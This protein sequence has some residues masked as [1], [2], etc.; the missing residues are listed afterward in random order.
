MQQHPPHHPQRHPQ[1][2]PRYPQ[3][4]QPYPPGPGQPQQPQDQQP[5]QEFRRKNTIA[6]V[7]IVLGAL[8][9][10]LFIGIMVIFGKMVG[11]GDDLEKIN[12]EN[13]QLKHDNKALSDRNKFL[14]ETSTAGKSSAGGPA[15]ASYADGAIP[16]STDQ[17]YWYNRCKKLEKDLS[18]AIKNASYIEQHM[19]SQ[20]RKQMKEGED[21]LVEN[22]KMTETADGYRLTFEVVNKAPKHI[23]NVVGSVRIWNGDRIYKEF[24]FHFAE[25]KA[26]SKI[27]WVIDITPKMN[28]AFTYD[29]MVKGGGSY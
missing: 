28:F 27:P 19:S 5:Y 24:P 16:A 3:Q 13:N 17:E 14:E 15:K 8:C 7:T 22:Y 18:A 4:Q 26:R 20:D 29:G 23:S 6:P 25:I 11:L 2:P 10:V 12:A 21:L 9:L 1:H